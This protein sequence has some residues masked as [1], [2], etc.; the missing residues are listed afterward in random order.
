MMGS[1]PEKD[2]KFINKIMQ[3]INNG[4]DKLYVVNDKDGTPTYTIE[5]A[6]TCK[7]LLEHEYWGLY[8]C[9][10]KG[11]TSRYEV[12]QEM[13]N[14]L[15]LSEKIEIIPVDS[16]YF[17]KDYFAPR[18]ACERLISRKLD[19]LGCNKMG[20]WKIALND[21]LTKNYMNKK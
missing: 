14:I 9:T 17:A 13:L 18:P 20:D 12:A 16:S 21:Y 1:G 5:F 4:V 19:I 7:E 15:S 8:N 2:K 3:Q 10:C 6:Q 11:F